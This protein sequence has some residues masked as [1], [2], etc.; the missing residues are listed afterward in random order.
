MTS[1]PWD[2]RL[3]VYGMLIGVLGAA[4]QRLL[5]HAVPVGPTHSI[6]PVV[7]LSPVLTIAI[8]LLAAELLA[9]EPE[10]APVVPLAARA[11]GGT[12]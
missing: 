8:S 1:R 11:P 9:I 10:P 5:F 12:R 3:V 2:A 4:G 7:S 6:S